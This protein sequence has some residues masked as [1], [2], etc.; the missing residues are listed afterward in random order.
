MDLVCSVVAHASP[1]ASLVGG[2]AFLLPSLLPLGQI[3]L[4][5]CT[6]TP[7]LSTNR[8]KEREGSEESQVS[9]HS[10]EAIAAKYDL[11]ELSLYSSAGM[12]A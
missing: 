1:R 7:H 5:H 6:T 8:Q 12:F 2:G 3:A 11:E 4:V 10:L 9:A